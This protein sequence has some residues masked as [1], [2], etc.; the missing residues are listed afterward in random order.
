VTPSFG[1]SD[2]LLLAV[3]GILA[4]GG[5]LA[6]AGPDAGPAVPGGGSS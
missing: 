3:G 4:V 2:F 1:T 6:G 5:M